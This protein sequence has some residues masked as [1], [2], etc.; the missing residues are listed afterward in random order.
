[1][2]LLLGGLLARSARPPPWSVGLLAACA[3]IAMLAGGAPVERAAPLYGPGLLL[4]AELARWALDLARLG[5]EPSGL[6]RRRL[7]TLLAVAAASAPLAWLVVLAGG[8]AGAGSG[9]ELRVLGAVAAIAVAWLLAVL[10]RRG[11][12][13]G[14]P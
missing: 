9:V 3:A 6:A 14:G 1:M 2:G 8:L 10:A 7:A 12:A 4:L 5:A 11:T 13:G